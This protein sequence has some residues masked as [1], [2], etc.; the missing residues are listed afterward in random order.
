MDKCKAD[1]VEKENNTLVGLREENIMLKNRIVHLKNNPSNVCSIHIVYFADT[2][3]FYTI[4]ITNC[5]CPFS[6]QLVSEGLI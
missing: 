3:I 5:K 2:I 4:Y 6:C 1:L